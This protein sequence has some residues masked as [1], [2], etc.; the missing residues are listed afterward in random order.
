VINGLAILC[1]RCSGRPNADDL[2]AAFAETIIGGPTSFVIRA[3][4]DDRFAEAV[5][6]KLILEIAGTQ[7][8]PRGGLRLVTRDR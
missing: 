8:A 3:D 4:G 7:P 1:R 2:E 6:K 5:R